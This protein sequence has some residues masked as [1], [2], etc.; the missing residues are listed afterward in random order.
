[1]RASFV[2]LVSLIFL[3]LSPT[4]LA[5]GKKEGPAKVSFHIE[6]SGQDNPKMIFPQRMAG[7][8]RFFRRMP[9]VSTQ[10]IAAFNP[11]P[12]DG[13]QGYAVAFKLKSHAAKRLSAITNV[14]HGKWLLAQ[15]NGRVVDGVLIDS[16]IDDGVLVVWRNVTLQDI[17][18]LDETFPRPGQDGKKKKKK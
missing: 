2:A 14:N 17:A 12:A 13:G 5:G 3:C 9:E 15:V 8:D 4:L 11:F 18:A 1:M 16:T 6:T 10:D 7:K